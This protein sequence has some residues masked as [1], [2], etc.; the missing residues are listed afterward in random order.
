MHDEA[1]AL[2]ALK[3]AL[4]ID[5]GMMEAHQML[6]NV[7]VGQRKFTEAALHVAA[8]QQRAPQASGGY[9]LEGD[10]KSAQGQHAAALAA[11]EKA[12]ALEPGSGLLIQL[13]DALAAAGKPAEA[14][15]RMLQWLHQHPDDIPAR[16][17]DASSKLV[18]SD[19]R[20]AIAQLE[21]VLKRAPNN[22]LALNDLAWAFQR[23]N[24]KGA[25]AY[26][27]RA[28]R[29]APD[30]PAIMDTLGWI[31]LEN[32][33][34]ARAL[35]LLQ[36]ASALA[37]D[38]V[39]IRYHFGLVLAKSGDKRGARRELE[40]LLASPAQFSKRAEAKAFLATL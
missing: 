4:A 27:E 1:A 12:Y 5:P 19:F 17:H 20:G 23:I 9:K 40:R 11:Y 2:A 35:P 8:L 34:I 38:A 29:L 22:V 3:K 33:D 37:P 25:L 16:M 13:H 14:E 10:L 21:A 28:S 36:K 31:C 30:N 39:E 15:A 26:A 7:L 18:R 6:Q 24:D 32:G